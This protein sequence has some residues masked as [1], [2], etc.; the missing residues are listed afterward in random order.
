MLNSL[1]VTQ[2]Y[3]TSIC[4]DNFPCRETNVCFFFFFFVSHP[5]ILGKLWQFYAWA[6]EGERSTKQ[7][8]IIRD[9]NARTL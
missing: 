5:T 6:D 7:K 1:Q 3:Y 4:L 8:S 2:K 9:L